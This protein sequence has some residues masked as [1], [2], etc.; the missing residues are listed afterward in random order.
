MNK[1]KLPAERSMASPERDCEIY[2]DCDGANALDCYRKIQP[3]LPQ[4]EECLC[5]ICS[6]AK[7]PIRNEAS[8][9]DCDPKGD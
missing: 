3:T 6:K 9:I 5:S 8:F 1:P 4:C 7:C 2:E